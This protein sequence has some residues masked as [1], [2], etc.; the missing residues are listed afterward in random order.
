MATSASAIQSI[1]LANRSPVTQLGHKTRSD[2]LSISSTYLQRQQGK[3]NFHVRCLAEESKRE[4]SPVSST[5][6]VPPSNP[7]PSPPPPKVS[8]KFEDVL[9]FSGPAPERINGRLAMVGFVAA[10]GAELA[11]GDDVIGQLMNGG[12]PWFLGTTVVLS[13][14]SLI[15]L[16]KGV[17]VQSKSEGIMTSDAE[18]LNGRLAMLGLVALVFTEYVK[19][20]ALV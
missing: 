2:S 16:F 17:T 20:G 9:A 1:F 6:S 8:T 7:T 18:L 19:G 4:Q 13:L 3:A 15:P 14:A 11:R 5:P 12:I 10:L